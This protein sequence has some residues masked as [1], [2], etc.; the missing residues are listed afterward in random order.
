[1]STT[2]PD[3]EL[4]R[5]LYTDVRDYA[6][7]HLRY[8]RLDAVSKLSA[9]LTFFILSLTTIC[10]CAC[11]L[12]FLTFQ[13]AFFFASLWGSLG[14]AILT[15]IGIY[16]MLFA[17]I[18]L[19]RRNWIQQP[20]TRMLLHT[21]SLHTE[22]LSTNPIEEI[23]HQKEQLQYQIHQHQKHL[24]TTLYDLLAPPPHPTLMDKIFSLAK[25]STAI[26]KG[27]KLGFDFIKRRRETIT[28]K[29]EGVKVNDER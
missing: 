6:K 19:N 15:I 16:L 8:A 14:L 21:F 23:D 18:Y 10:L 27:I 7:P 11:L 1:M 25:H 22:E 3:A 12:I 28:V 4:F 20:V 29:D 5:K 17:L 2:N 13:A 9:L 26:I 24:L